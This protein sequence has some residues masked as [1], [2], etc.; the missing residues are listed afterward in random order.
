MTISTQLLQRY[1]LHL[2]ELAAQGAGRT[3]VEPT[4]LLPQEG[5]DEPR[6][7]RAGELLSQSQRVL[8]V[9]GPG[10]G[11]SELLCWLAGRMAEVWLQQGG[12]AP[13]PFL[14]DLRRLRR[15]EGL[16]GLV[17]GALG[18]C[19]L[20]VEPDAVRRFLRASPVFLLLDN[21]DLVGDTYALAEMAASLAQAEETS[22]ASVVACRET[23]LDAYQAHLRGHVRATLAPWTDAQVEEYVERSLPPEQASWLVER[24]QSQGALWDLVHSP[25][26][27]WAAVEVTR[28]GGR[29]SL[30]GLSRALVERALARLL[31]RLEESA[32]QDGLQALGDGAAAPHLPEWLAQVAWSLR[33]SGRASLSREE[34]TD[35]VAAQGGEAASRDLPALLDAGVLAFTPDRGGVRFLHEAVADYFAAR[36][37]RGMA[38]R[39]DDPT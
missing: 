3:F 32:G 9:A 22:V 19:Q 16:A 20:Q 28:E 38:E 11:K 35:L 12:D 39:M 29:R 18:A 34:F 27:L 24:L 37:L 7:C 2:R 15:D 1:L 26:F 25:L 30:A 23:G 31:A 4:L 36:A 13:V 10:Q 6:T 21:L 33:R 5:Q 14:L 8:V 17:V